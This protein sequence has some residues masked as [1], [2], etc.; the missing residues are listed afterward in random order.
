[1]NEPTARPVPK[2]PGRPRIHDSQE[3]LRAIVLGDAPVF[4][5]FTGDDLSTNQFP[6]H[7]YGARAGLEAPRFCQLCGRKMVVQVRPDGWSA[8]CSRHGEVDSAALERR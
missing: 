5:P 8:V 3:L 2:W 4:D 7:S 6:E 1:M